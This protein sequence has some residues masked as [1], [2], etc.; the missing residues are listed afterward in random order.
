MPHEAQ[1][2][3]PALLVVQRPVA[4]VSCSTLSTNVSRMLY[5]YVERAADSGISD[6]FRPLLASL[7]SRQV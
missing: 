7:P 6:M 2:I 3:R 5:V 4:A 1:L